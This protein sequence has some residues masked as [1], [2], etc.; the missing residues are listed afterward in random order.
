MGETM[1]YNKLFMIYCYEYFNESDAKMFHELNVQELPY[2]RKFSE[3]T[4]E[5]NNAFLE[6]WRKQNN[7]KLSE[8]KLMD[9]PTFNK[10]GTPIFIKR[11]KGEY[12]DISFGGEQ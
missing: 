12:K 1:N 9:R 5:E 2:P 7:I 4:V 10:F 6:E 11:I 8:F 3:H